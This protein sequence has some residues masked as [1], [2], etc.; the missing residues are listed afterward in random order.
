MNIKTVKIGIFIPGRLNSER[1]PNKLIL[2]LNDKGDT[3]WD[4]ACNKLNSLPLDYVKVA[5]CNDKELVDIANKYYNIKVI[6]RDV[7]TTKAEGPMSYIFKDLK[8]VEDVTHWMF[9][10][11]CLALLKKHVIKEALEIFENNPYIFLTSVKKYQNWMFDNKG[12]CLTGIDYNT[13]STKE[14]EGKY[15]AAHAFHIFEKEFLFTEDKNKAM[16]GLKTSLFI[17]PKE[18]LLDV[19]T[20]EDYLFLKFFI[21]NRVTQDEK[22]EKFGRNNST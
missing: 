10:N 18:Q 7:E 1:L 14:I 3:L 8:G 17:I 6:E 12:D 11:P 16:E 2:P 9:L 22:K 19:D 4:I 20:K 5:L 15:E 21:S 13:L